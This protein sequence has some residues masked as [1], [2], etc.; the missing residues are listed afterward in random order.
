MSTADTVGFAVVPEVAPKTPAALAC[1]CSF[2]AV[3]W[4]KWTPC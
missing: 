2:Q 1:N 4:L 3:I